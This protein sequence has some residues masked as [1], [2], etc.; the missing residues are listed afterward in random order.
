[1][2]TTMKRQK[3]EGDIEHSNLHEEPNT[4]YQSLMLVAP[5][6]SD[7]ETAKDTAGAPP[8]THMRSVLKGITWRVIA[9][10]TTMAIAW[11]ITGQVQ[12]ALEIGFIEVFAKIM[13]YYVHE[14]LWA[15]I[16]V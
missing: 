3:A 16:R 11:F 2:N 13:I 8:E 15:R 1:M 9:T 14:R 7:G 6:G 4:N 12:L 5:P 10:S